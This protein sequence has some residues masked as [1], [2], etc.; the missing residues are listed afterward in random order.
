MTKKRGK[1]KELAVDWSECLE[2]QENEMEALKAIYDEDFIDETDAGDTK[3]RIRIVP[4]ATRSD[5]TNHCC[6]FLKVV[7]PE[8]YPFV[9]PKVKVEKDFGL[10]DKHLEELT[11]G[12][13][14]LLQE[15]DGEVIVYTYVS[16]RT[17]KILHM[18]ASDG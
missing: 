4:F 8:K 10:S 17:S 14:S 1:K 2:A 3:F 13:H 16:C 18:Q 7:Y 9:L 6:I 11:E 12:I 15:M 5:E